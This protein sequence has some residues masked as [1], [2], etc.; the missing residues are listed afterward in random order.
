MA[1]LSGL[2]DAQIFFGVE[3]M[4]RCHLRALKAWSFVEM[5]RRE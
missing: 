4:T 2:S 5:S 1:R 3:E